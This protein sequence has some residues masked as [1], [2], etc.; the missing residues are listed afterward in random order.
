[1]TWWRHAVFPASQLASAGLTLVLWLIIGQLTD[2]EAKDV[3]IGSYALGVPASLV[4][5]LGIPFVLPNTFRSAGGDSRHNSGPWSIPL[6]IALVFSVSIGTAGVF[7]SA[8]PAN[9]HNEELIAAT[10]A[11]AGAI[12]A[13]I[14][15]AQV[16]RAAG[17]LN[18]VIAGQL[19]VPATAVAWLAAIHTSED[20]AQRIRIACALMFSCQAILAF[21]LRRYLGKCPTDSA[22][23]RRLIMAAA[24]LIPHLL[25]FGVIIQ[26]ARIVAVIGGKP[27]IVVDTAHTLMLAFSVGLTFLASINSYVAPHLQATPDDA[28]STTLNRS[29]R[30]Y[31]LAVI[32][33]VIAVWLTLWIFNRAS[34][35]TGV[36]VANYAYI[37]IALASV[38]TYYSISAQ[39]VRELKT[40]PLTIAS[41]VGATT[42]VAPTIFGA[43]FSLDGI[44]ANFAAACITL[45]AVITIISRVSRDHIRI[46]FSIW[47]PIALTIL[48]AL[49]AALFSRN[50]P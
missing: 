34:L 15:T 30:I 36:T 4:V 25:M 9:T 17:Q 31:S 37:A 21:L 23:L 18:L 7:Q 6:G 11:M 44:V 33:S 20:R 2:T 22:G 50:Y 19:A 48:W 27:A 3:A 29:L 45:P 39:W 47:I 35:L 49:T 8:L 32:G 42:L 16:G 26:G 40:A 5:T 12:A 28:Y 14:A 38:G 13:G 41:T 1:M 43:Q 24:L 10:L 46:R